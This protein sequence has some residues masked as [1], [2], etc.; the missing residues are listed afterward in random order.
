ML[1]EALLAHLKRLRAGPYHATQFE[2]LNHPVVTDT[3]EVRAE[4]TMNPRVVGHV[5]GPILHQQA[6][7]EGA[8]M[9][10][11]MQLEKEHPVSLPGLQSLA[12]AGEVK[13]QDLFVPKTQAQ[14]L[15]REARFENA[16]WQLTNPH[17]VQEVLDFS[18]GSL[19]QSA[20]ELRFD[21]LQ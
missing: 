16:T 19:A 3:L 7:V 18:E 11:H 2:K 5:V 6:Q 1:R 9:T 14:G 17:I 4:D 8:A 15:P 10:Q 13:Q 12:M 21:C 20:L